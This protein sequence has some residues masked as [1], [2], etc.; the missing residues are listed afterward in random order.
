MRKNIVY[1]V[2][3]K[4]EVESTTL[5]ERNIQFLHEVGITDITVVVG[6]MKELYEFLI[7][8]YGVKLVY[9]KDYAEKNNLHS[10]YKVIDR[11]DNTYILPCDVWCESNPFSTEEL[12]SWY[13]MS[14]QVDD[15]NEGMRVN[16]Q[17]IIVRSKSH[18]QKMIGIS[19]ITKDLESD[20]KESMISMVNNK[21]YDNSFWESAL[22][23]H[24]RKVFANLWNG[25]RVKE[26]NT[27]EQLRDLDQHSNQLNNDAIST[28]VYELDV[29]PSDIVDIRV[30]KKGMTNRSF[31]FKCLGSKYIMRIPGEGTDQ[32]INREDEAKVYDVISGKGLCDDNIYLNPKNGY[33]ITKFIENVRNADAY[34]R[35]DVEKCMKKLKYFDD[36]K[37]KVNHTFDLYE[38]INFYESLWEGKPSIY[39]D[40][41]ETKEH[42]FEIKSYID[43]NALPYQ[44]THIDAV[45]DNFLFSKNEDGSEKLDLT[46]WEYAGMQDPHV[47]I[48][49]FAI[50]A[51]YEGN[52]K[53]SGF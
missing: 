7:D 5:I 50:Y 4:R 29:K 31:F 3:K 28:I 20:L 18:A 36:L 33:K 41:R 10:L 37:L 24:K 48:A 42:V 14:T 1:F 51:L 44:L 39:R 17:S 45:C 13:M 38:R 9:N 11:I 30:L 19:Y 46:D 8:K 47:D 40:Y 35:S 49:M 52:Q 22:F 23:D 6:F 15:K 32:L 2:H 21:E 43:Q 25:D 34:K 16:K 26:I 27:Y 53:N 12:Y